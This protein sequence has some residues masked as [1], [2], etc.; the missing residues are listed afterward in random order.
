MFLMHR[1]LLQR[2]HA[3]FNLG[4]GVFEILLNISLPNSLCNL[5]LGLWIEGICIQQSL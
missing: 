4:D 1:G 5:A 3:R 2:E